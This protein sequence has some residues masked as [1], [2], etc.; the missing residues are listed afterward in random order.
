VKKIEPALG[1]KA[2]EIN[3]EPIIIEELLIANPST[4]I[5]ADVMAK[6]ARSISSLAFFIKR[7]YPLLISSSVNFVFILL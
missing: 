4:Q 7:E 5:M 3:I 6:K 1:T 2:G